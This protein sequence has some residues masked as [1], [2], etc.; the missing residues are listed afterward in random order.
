M[1]ARDGHAVAL[2]AWGGVGKT[3]LMLQLVQHR[4]WQFLAD[5]LAVLD[6]SG[7]VYRS[8]WRIPVYAHS[9]DGKGELRRRL[10]TGRGLVDR[11]Q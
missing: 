10:F 6:D 1:A 3:S 4:G 5:D 2:A 9:L 8:P 7:A 11:L